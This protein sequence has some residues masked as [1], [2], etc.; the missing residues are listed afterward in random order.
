[1]AIVK[2]EI[3][4]HDSGWAYRVGG[5]YS[6]TFPSH[7]AALAAARRAAGEQRVPDEDTAIEWED[8]AGKWH[9]EAS[10]GHDRPATEID[11]DPR[12]IKGRRSTKARVRG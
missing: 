2:Y 10:S 3:V 5:T 7:D 12:S 8:E 11:D 6:E 1:M 4:R 9:S